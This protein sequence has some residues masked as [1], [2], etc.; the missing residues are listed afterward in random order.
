MIVTDL[1]WKDKKGREHI[2]YYL[3]SYLKNNLDEIPTGFLKKDWDCVAIV[4]GHGKVRIG[5]S[6]LA[7]QMAYYIAWLL[8]GGKMILDE[9]GGVIG[10]KSP[11]KPVNFSHLNVVFDPDSLMKAA[12]KLP[13]HSVIVY[14]EGR[15]GLDAIRAMENINKGMMDFFLECGQY[16]H[17]IFI[18]LP[19][20]F[21][22]VEDIAVS[23]SLFLVDVFAIRSKRPMG[24]QQRGYFNF[25]NENQK[26]RL[27]F[28][29]KRKIGIVSKYASTSESFWGRFV[30]FFPINKRA[31]MDKKRLVLKRK[32]L[33]KRE[34]RFMKQRNAA[35][36]MLKK[37][38]GLE[39]GEIA[40][41][42]TALSGI[43]LSSDVLGAI[44]SN[45]TKGLG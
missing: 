20:Y 40:S 45:I 29:G 15:A 21:R 28:F 36:Y 22:L 24:G 32:R 5:K 10:I 44:I 35:I 23:R 17:V 6:T 1:K 34:K 13:R 8:A 4:S 3:N 42:L 41:E 37:Y 18:V 38:S 30:K 43:K 9:K 12:E 31:Y 2:G 7:V 11:T 16:G 14:D 39:M 26:E 25:Y 19:N 33:V 27:Y